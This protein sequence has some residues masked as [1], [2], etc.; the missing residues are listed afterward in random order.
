MIIKFQGLLMVGT[1]L[2]RWLEWGAGG[3]RP[4][5]RLG[6]EGRSILYYGMDVPKMYWVFLCQKRLERTCLLGISL[7]PFIKDFNLIWLTHYLEICTISIFRGLN[8]VYK[9]V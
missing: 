8:I 1:W 6:V 9:E 2:I 4:F 5:W 7:T 3:C